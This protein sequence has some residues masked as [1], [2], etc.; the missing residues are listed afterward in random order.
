MSDLVLNRALLFI[1]IIMSLAT[2]CLAI[3]T[4]ALHSEY[5]AFRDGAHVAG[6]VTRTE[7]HRTYVAVDVAYTGRNGPTTLTTYPSLAEA[8][9]Y[10]VGMRVVLLE[11]GQGTILASKLAD[12]EVPLGLPVGG[13]VA[14]V[15][16]IGCFV[17]DRRW[18]IERSMVGDA[19]DPLAR[20]LARTRNAWVSAAVL[21]FTFAPF[22]GVVAVESS[23]AASV[24][25]LVGGLA[26]LAFGTAAWFAIKGGRL[27]DPRHNRVFDLITQHPSEIASIRAIEEHKRGM[28][29]HAIVITTTRKERHALRVTAQDMHGLLADLARRAP[30][31]VA[32]PAS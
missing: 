11:S 13:V 18:R 15:L 27:R 31:A 10:A 5:A 29:M 6:T 2:L 32:A 4:L 24:R 20:A 30:H 22:L 12:R 8:G 14:L 25:A 28:V 7:P 21:F 16:A 26:V 23:D 17:L 3:P 9:S 19:L 1:A